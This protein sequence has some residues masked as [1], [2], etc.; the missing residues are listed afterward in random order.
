MTKIA[1]AEACNT[2]IPVGKQTLLSGDLFP[3]LTF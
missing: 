1:V 3:V 2:D